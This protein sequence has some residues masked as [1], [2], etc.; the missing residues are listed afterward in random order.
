MTKS[1]RKK[2]LYYV[3]LAALA[4]FVGLSGFM[5]TSRKNNHHTNTPA[6]Q[7]V[8]DGICVALRAEKADPDTITVKAGEFVQFNSADGKTHRLSLGKGGEDHDHSGP[9]NS[10]DFK[11]DEAWRVQF[12]EP[13]T[14]SFHDHY[15]P[16]INILV[17]VYNPA[18]S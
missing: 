1:S 5:I 12:K 14:F 16:D 7:T 8:C 15:N 2:A 13:G 11:A 17:V 18:K 6:Q 3:G 4:L 9:F 10:G